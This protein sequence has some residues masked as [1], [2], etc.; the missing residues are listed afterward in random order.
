MAVGEEAM[1][2]R[3]AALLIITC[4][5]AGCPYDRLRPPYVENMMDNVVEVRILL[6]NG[7]E[8]VF[9][10]R[11]GDRL[12]YSADHTAISK[13]TF[14]SDGDVIDELDEERIATMLQCT[15][16][17]RDVTWYIEANKLRPSVPC[18]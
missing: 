2:T 7:T 6:I 15:A 18:R 8:N 17:P 11:T 13:V 9:T 3:V 12:M 5:L 1:N 10:L 16:D 14:I 4:V